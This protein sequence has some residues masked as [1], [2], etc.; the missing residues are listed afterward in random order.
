MARL[1]PQVVPRGCEGSYD[2]VQ[3]CVA[4]EIGL[5][6]HIAALVLGHSR[7][8]LFWATFGDFQLH[9]KQATLLHELSSAHGSSERATME[10]PNLDVVMR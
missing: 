4:Y 10:E 5:E 8:C 6:R 2:P 9:I 1:R 3:G 7:I